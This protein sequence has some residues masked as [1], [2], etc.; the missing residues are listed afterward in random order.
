MSPTESAGQPLVIVLLGPTASGKTDLAIALAQALD[1]AVLN[2]DSRQLYRQMDVG[3]AKPT[4]AQRGQARHELL[5]LRDPDQPINLQEFRAI[6][7]AQLN[8]ELASKPLALLA[9]GSGLYLQ[10]LTQGLE[11]PAVPP[12][13]QLRAQ[14]AALGQPL[15][16]QLLR[17]GDPA[18]AA[19]IAP[20]DAVRT[21][22]ALEVLY[23]TGRP[24][25]SQ[26]GATPPPWRVLELGL[27]PTDLTGRIASRTKGLFAAGLVAETEALIERYGAGLPLLNTIGY[28]E[29]KQQLAG[30]LSE[31]EAIALC[32]QRTRQFAKRQ[33]TW[34]RR[35]HEPIW[36][37][38]R[39]TEGQLAQ[40]LQV[41]ERGLG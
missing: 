5:D 31:T 11:P 32:E 12:Q 9:G 7:E 4:A 22:R 27:N 41:V 16:H 28:G 24:L 35:R 34:F 17:Q 15:C 30:E 8:A 40:A 2:V 36:L 38:E 19:R 33:R 6:A 25:S 29:A 10:A 1:L 3:T 13:P 37:E 21:Q 18:A 20:A 26:Q 39:S 23:A 14:L